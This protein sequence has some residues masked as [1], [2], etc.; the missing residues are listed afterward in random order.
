MSVTPADIAAAAKTLEGRVL[1]TPT[2]HAP[3]LSAL[4]GAEIFI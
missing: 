3:R 2:L 1:R 4:T